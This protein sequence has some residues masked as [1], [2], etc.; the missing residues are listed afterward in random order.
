[1][2]LRNLPGLSSIPTE[3]P[4]NLCESEHVF[5]SS[6]QQSGLFSFQLIHVNWEWVFRLDWGQSLS[7]TSMTDSS[8]TSKHFSVSIWFPQSRCAFS[9]LDKDIELS[10]KGIGKHIFLETGP[11]SWMFFLETEYKEAI[12]KPHF[13]S[14]VNILICQ[15]LVNHSKMS[16]SSNTSFYYSLLSFSR[17]YIWK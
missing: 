5:M 13:E 3:H 7:V 14:L 15:P 1:M 17:K 4:D 2:G 8:S 6:E 10:F 12:L 11:K 9:P 16:F